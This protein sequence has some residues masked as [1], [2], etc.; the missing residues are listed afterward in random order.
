MLWLLCP[1]SKDALVTLSPNQKCFGYFAPKAK[2][3]QEMT[4]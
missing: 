2:K 4:V 1:Q 3:T